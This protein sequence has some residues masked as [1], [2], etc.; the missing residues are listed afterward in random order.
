MSGEIG[1][2]CKN[3]LFDVLAARAERLQ[4][5]GELS[6]LAPRDEAL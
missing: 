6:L 3:S 4:V 5:T 2:S 1:G